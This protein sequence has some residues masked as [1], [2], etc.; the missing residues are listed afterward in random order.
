MEIRKVDVEQYEVDIAFGEA[1]EPISPRYGYGGVEPAPVEVT[2]DICQFWI[3]GRNSELAGFL[4][5]SAA[6]ILG[7]ISATMSSVLH[8]GSNPTQ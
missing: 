3:P 8:H 7:L 5:S 2:L 1:L 4:G 6:A